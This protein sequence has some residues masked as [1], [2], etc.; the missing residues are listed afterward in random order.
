[1]KIKNVMAGLVLVAGLVSGAAQASLVDRGGGMIY[2]DVLNVTWLQDAN[3]AKTSGYDADGLM[4]WNVAN[5]WATN[6][7][8]GGYNDW[9]LASNRPLGNEWNIGY[10]NNGTTDYGYNITSPNFELAYMYYVNLGL[11]GYRYPNGVFQSEFGVFG[12][13]AV[14]GQRDIGQIVN[15]QSNFYWSGLFPAWSADSYAWTFFS[16]TG[17]TN[18]GTPTG[19]CYA[20]AVRDGDVAAPTQVPEPTSI[21]LLGVAL[22]GLGA[23]R[24]RKHKLAT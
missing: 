16:S 4:T 5:D 14:G 12:N 10:S 7:V 15:F 22:A 6:L 17:R 11:L 8:Y 24:R 13:G 20:W 2:D 3:Y 19:E 1:M 18:Y 21:A 9:R 23:T